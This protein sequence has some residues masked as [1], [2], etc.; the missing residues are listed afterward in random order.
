MPRRKSPVPDLKYH[1]PTRQFCVYLD[2]KRVTL[3]GD[4]TV[5]ERRHKQLCREILDGRADVPS[6]NT[7][8]RKA[9]DPLA[10]AEGLLRYM[11]DHALSYYRDQP[12]TVARLW[13]MVDAVRLRHAELPADRF[14][15]RELKAVRQYLLDERRSKRDGRPLSR[16]Y[17]NYLV[18]AAQRCWVWLL[19]EGDVSAECVES[20]RAVE[21]IHK[22]KGGR[23]PAR[24]LPP[25]PGWSMALVELP[26]TLYAMCRVQALSGMRPQD[27]C[28]M[29]RGEV[30]TRPDESVELAGTGRKLSAIAVGGA[31]VWVYCPSDHKTAH[32]GKPRAVPLGPRCQQLLR[33][34]LAGLGPDDYVFS[35]ARALA[36]VGRGNRFKRVGYSTRYAVKQYEQFVKRAIDRVNRRLAAA[37]VDAES[38]A[39]VWSPNQLRHLAATEVGDRFDRHTAAALLGHAGDNTI[40]VYL[41]QSLGKA[42]RAA[43]E[44]G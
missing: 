44:C 29:R 6:G 26:P 15:G 30:S 37:G 7:P 35:P 33:P 8:L 20:L 11:R 39:P 25:G 18:R 36:E 42:A 14:R 27:V 4:R 2:G 10:V 9:G 23:E 5:A 19:S 31:L 32:K 43:A 16:T 40:D 22:G 28:R 17:V 38:H 24:V 13:E 41:E 1:K 21:A 12:A 34:L 3:G